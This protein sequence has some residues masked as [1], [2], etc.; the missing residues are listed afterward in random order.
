[1]IDGVKCSCFGLDADL[2]RNNPLLDFKLSVSEST[3]EIYTQ[4]REAKAHS[5]RFVL[6][7]TN[8]GNFSC[9]FNG[10]LHKHKNINGINWDDFTF[11]QLSETLNSLVKDYDIDLSNSF[12][13][14]LEIGVN[15]ELDYSPSI[16]LK[17]VICHK[18]KGFDS[19]WKIQ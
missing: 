5:L 6:S 15:I 3:G 19:I 16:I 10:S 12:I 17:S 7:P 8:K 9:S 2:W 13:H 14:S 4:R 11:L 1:M 18:N